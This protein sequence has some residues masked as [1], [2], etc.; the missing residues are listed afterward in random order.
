[1]ALKV[2]SE[3]IEIVSGPLLIPA[4]HELILGANGFTVNEHVQQQVSQLLFKMRSQRGIGVLL[5]PTPAK[6]DVSRPNKMP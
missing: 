4:R 2:W 6:L 3:I 1:M 5:F